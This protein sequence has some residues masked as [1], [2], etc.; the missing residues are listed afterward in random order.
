MV[1]CLEA[2]RIRYYSKSQLDEVKGLVGQ[3]L[4][5]DIT[6]I[7]REMLCVFHD[8]LIKKPCCYWNEPVF[9][10]TYMQLNKLLTEQSSS[11]SI[12]Y[13]ILEHFFIGYSAYNQITD[14][15]KNPDPRVGVS[16]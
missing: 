11:I 5:P 7:S 10:Q 16:G 2:V 3:K 13:D 12:N 9:K 8:I 4:D 15:M 1:N 14:I 6:S